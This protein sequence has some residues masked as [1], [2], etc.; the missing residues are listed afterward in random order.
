MI[1]TGFSKQVFPRTFPANARLSFS[2]ELCSM[3]AAGE[4][5]QPDG[6]IVLAVHV[7]VLVQVLNLRK[8]GSCTH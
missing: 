6:H 5:G 1:P 4:L 3:E 7:D 8:Q 2:R